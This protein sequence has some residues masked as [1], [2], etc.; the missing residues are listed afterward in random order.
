MSCAN[1][2]CP[3]WFRAVL[4]CALAA[5]GLT[6]TSPARAGQ[7]VIIVQSTTSTENSGLFDA[8]LPQFEA[9]SGIDVR[10]VAVGTGQAIRNAERGDGDVLF[11]HA[12]SAEEAF[13]AKGFGVERFDV[14]YNDFVL[15]GP[16]SDPAGI[17]GMSDAAAALAAIAE[18]QAVF[19]SRGDDSG[20]HKAERR[21][22]SR[23]GVVPDGASGTWYRETGS[24]MG[25]TLNIAIAMGAYALTDRGTW[26]AFGNKGRHRILVEGDPALFNQYGVTLVN[27]RRHPRVNARAGQV[28]V[29]WILSEPGQSAIA[30]YRVN[31]Q[32]LFFPNARP[33]G[34]P[35]N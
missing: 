18:K 15:V 14:M 31:G 21:L 1:R 7:E 11:V 23:A 22:W 25:A 8:I 26:I 9:A 29:D 3:G 28:F 2:R 34:Q 10:V 27:P 12:K 24:G 33:A 30:A 4:F 19:A 17:A 5:P 16:D 32:Q 6:A 20:T 13:V 35:G